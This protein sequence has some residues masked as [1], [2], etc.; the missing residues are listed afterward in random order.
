MNKVIYQGARGCF[1]ELA[2]QRYFGNGI[3]IYGVKNF[4]DVFETIMQNHGVIGIIPIENSLSGSI[5]RNYDLLLAYRYYI[6]GEIKLKI[7]YNLFTNVGTG[8][9]MI[10]EVWSH[11]ATLDQCRT[12]F[13]ANPRLKPV[14]VYDSAGAAK[15]L[16]EKRKKNAAIIAGPQVEKIY[17]LRMLEKGVEDNPEN[18]TRFLLISRKKNVYAGEA[19]KTT[20]V[21]GV[22]NEPGILFRCLSI[23][24]LR[25]IDLTKLESRPNVGRPWEYLFYIDFR[26]SI[27]DEPCQRALEDLKES[28]AF[29]RWLGSYEA[30][31][32]L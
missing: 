21:F 3:R 9:R 13:N 27:K 2:A 29:V 5:H 7:T 8:P 20:A 1:S 18:Y 22:Q 28:V 30:K 6:I 31:E 15:L 10:R 26:G 25:N 23:F 32:T 4:D 11:P 24:A 16:K 12:F 19:A 14:A 17:G